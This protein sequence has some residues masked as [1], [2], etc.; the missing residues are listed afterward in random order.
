MTTKEKDPVIPPHQQAEADKSPAQQLVA[1][2][3][4]KTAEPHPVVQP[5]TAPARRKQS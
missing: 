2:A 5:V 4:E 1:K 3:T